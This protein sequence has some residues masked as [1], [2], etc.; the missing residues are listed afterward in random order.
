MRALVLVLALIAGCSNEIGSRGRT[1]GAPPDGG[2]PPAD[3]GRDPIDARAPVDD[4]SVGIDAPVPA[5][6]GGGTPCTPTHTE[7]RGELECGAV[8]D[9]CPGGSID[10]G[11]CAGGELWCAVLEMPRWRSR[12]WPCVLSVRDAHPEYFDPAIECG[13]DSRFVI[14]ARALEYVRDV[15]ACV[16]GSGAIA[17]VDGNAPGHEIRVRGEDDDVADNHSVR[18]YGTGCTVGRYTSSCTPA[19]F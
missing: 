6:D 11:E 8:P 15:A 7:C 13:G 19:M 17:I 1:D 5:V 2:A 18:T 3:S 14:E 10:C 4:A 12:V 9:G 16:T